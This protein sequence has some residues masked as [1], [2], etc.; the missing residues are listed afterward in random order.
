MKRTTLLR[1]LFVCMLIAVSAT[2]WPLRAQPPTQASLKGVVTDPSGAFVPNALVILMG[3]DSVQKRKHTDVTGKYAFTALT[4][5]KYTVLVGA[6]GFMAFSREGVEVNGS[7]SLEVPLTI[8][9]ASEVVNV[10]SKENQVTVD[11]GS[12]SGALVLGEKELAALSDDPDELADELQAMAGPGTGPNGGQIYIDGF[13]GGNLPPKSSIREV[14]INSNPFS[15][16]YDRPGFGRIE[17]FTK[18]GTDA[19]RGQVFFQFNNQDFNTRSPLLDSALPTYKQ[20]FFGVNLSGPIIKQKASYTFDFE[21]RA[22]DENAFI[23]ATTF[24]T[25]LNVQTINQAVVTPQWRTTF[26]PRIDYSINAMN[27]LTVRYQDTRIELDQQGIGSFNLASQAYNQK[28]YEKTLQATETAILNP[29]VIN[30]TRF[31]FMRT[32]LTDIA[33]NSAPDINVQ[34]SFATGG[35]SIGDSGTIDN[36]L[37]LTNLTTFTHGTHTFKWGGRVRQSFLTD[38]S[39]NG[40]NGTFSFLGG[41]GPELDANNQA[42]AGTSEQL[43]ALEVYRRTLLFQNLGYS[44]AEIRALGGGATQFSIGGGTP[45]LSLN[46]LDLGVFF[47][48]DWRLRPN[49][50]LSYGLRYETQTNIHDY[51]DI[52]PRFALAWGI[53][54]GSGRRLRRCCAPGWE[55]SMTALPIP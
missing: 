4:P 18:P 6:K 16:E 25:N 15:P 43:T 13:T 35:A 51:A 55:L 33:N 14:R 39:F 26:S 7:T 48:D 42:I 34:G 49:L 10:D 24:D 2:T 47:N 21:R 46:Q 28:D 44:A 3:P 27:T 53:G 11:P 5:G 19:I 30:E 37:E 40:F 32:N 17:I 38:T 41:V 8:T 45:A 31:Q 1:T 12:N 50:T 36:R 22:I 29:N 20:E 54:G 23:L 9:A 52:A